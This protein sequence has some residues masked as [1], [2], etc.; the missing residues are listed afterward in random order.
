MEDARVFVP[1]RKYHGLGNDFIIV[2]ACS[3]HGISDATL[4]QIQDPA[5]IANLCNR[6][7]GIGADGVIFL[8]DGSNGCDYSTSIINSDGSIAQMCG[9]GIRC[10][11]K[12]IQDLQILPKNHQSSSTVGEII[13]IST[14][15][16]AIKLNFQQND[17]ICVDMGAP[18]L[19]PRQIP[20]RLE[21]H[22]FALNVHLP[23]AEKSIDC[24]C[25]SMGN[26]H[27]VSAACLY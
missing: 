2:D 19:L 20:T 25:V 6:R 11:G 27:C 26:P 8:F 5:V 1:F 14:L 18:R 22:E 23:F 17:S 15:A 3:P 10:L 7:R 13:T 9:N 21:S 24:S 4:K 12:F 16:G